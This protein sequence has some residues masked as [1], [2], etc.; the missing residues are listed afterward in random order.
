M[1]QGSWLLGASLP[2]AAQP[3]SIGADLRHHAHGL[4]AVGHVS[5]RAIF[6]HDN[7]GNGAYALIQYAPNGD[8]LFNGVG[9][10]FRAHLGG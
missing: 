2:R 3:V 1:R 6:G 7:L 4:V 10:T 8:L 5:V 9:G